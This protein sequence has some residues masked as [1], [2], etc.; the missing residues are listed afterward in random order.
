MSLQTRTVTISS[1]TPSLFDQLRR[2]HGETLS[3]PCSKIT[4]PYN[5]FVTNNVSFHPLCSSLF[6]S[7]QWIEALYLFDSSI[8]LPMDF[9]TT[10]STQVSKDL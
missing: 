2:E 9:R 8:Y 3:C 5:E 10:G 1:I 7:Q 6:V 4:I